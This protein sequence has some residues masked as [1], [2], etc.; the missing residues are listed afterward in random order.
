M[1]KSQPSSSPNSKN[2]IN[3]IFYFRCYV[4][5]K[6]GHGLDFPKSNLDPIQIQISGLDLKSISTLTRSNIFG[7]F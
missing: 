4:G 1:E 3:A 2:L 6:G 5:G 7:F